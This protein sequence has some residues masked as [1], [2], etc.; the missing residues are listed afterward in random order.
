MAPVLKATRTA[1]I[2][3]GKI[4]TIDGAEATATAESRPVPIPKMHALSRADWVPGRVSK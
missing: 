1:L 2:A 4:S 3:N